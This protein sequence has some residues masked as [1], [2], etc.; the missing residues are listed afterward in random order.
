M[1]TFAG[2]EVVLHGKIVPESVKE[3]DAAKR[4]YAFDLQVTLAAEPVEEAAD[5]KAAKKGKGKGKDKAPAKAAKETRVVHVT[6][7]FA[8]RQKDE[9]GKPID[10]SE[11][12]K[13][14]VDGWKS[15]QKLALDGKLSDGPT[16]AVVQRLT[17]GCCPPAPI[18]PTEI[19]ADV[20]MR[21]GLEAD[22]IK[23]QGRLKGKRTG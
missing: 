14:T 3:V 10:D 15:G 1:R 21:K 19:D 2:K 22:L 8:E 9:E 6:Y 16:L 5:P 12:V 23:A 4:I 13:S 18:T 20:A 7:A 11:M 17:L